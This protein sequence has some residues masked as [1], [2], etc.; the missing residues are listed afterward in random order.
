M[1]DGAPQDAKSVDLA[2]LAASNLFLF[3][4]WET[5][6]NCLIGPELPFDPDPPGLPMFLNNYRLPNRNGPVAERR[7]RRL[8]CASRCIRQSDFGVQVFRFFID[9]H[10]KRGRNFK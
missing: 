5:T 10:K 7:F 3:H 6:H 8:S 4:R 9:T 2:E 1:I